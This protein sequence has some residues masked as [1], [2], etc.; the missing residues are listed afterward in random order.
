[1]S[2]IL[3]YKCPCCGGRIEFDTKSQNMKCPYCDTEFDVNAIL[4]NEEALKDEAK[5]ELKWKKT[6]SGSFTQDDGMSLFSCNMCGG[7]IVCEDVTVATSCPYC[8]SPVVLVGRLEGE[9]RP[10]LVIP[11]KLDKNA[12][13]E[14]F[15]RHL[16]GK[17][18]LPKM[19]KSQNKIEEIKGVYVPFWLFDTDVDAKIRY[20]A[21]RTRFWS[22]SNY[23]YTETR[24]YS[25]I[26]EGS[27]GFDDVPVDGSTRL[28]DDLMES[29]EP[30]DYSEAI[31]FKTAYLSGFLA[32]K[33]DV[34]SETCVSRANQRIKKSTENSFART[35]AGYTSVYT[36][37]ST[38]VS[39][40]GRVRYALLPVWLMTASWN[41]KKYIFA[42]NGQT[43]KFVGNLPLDKKAYA[44]YFASF[45]AGLSAISF[46]A[47]WLI[48]LL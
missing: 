42:M 17:R 5:D 13:K 28:D 37:R 27:L 40:S 10:D 18:L 48:S 32:D 7:E 11:F 6:D 47:L 41:G 39:K 46:L 23:N 29:I 36:E 4:E 35:T 16:T 20:H 9:L 3:D 31:D 38:I 26:R 44:G 1:M 2:E 8:D 24:H 19:F 34:D 45:F 30:Y 25:L 21:T 43:G 22:D 33:Y 14:G 12:A 15:S